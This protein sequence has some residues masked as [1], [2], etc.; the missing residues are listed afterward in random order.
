MTPLLDSEKL[1]EGV[2]PG[3]WEGSA[4]DGSYHD[5]IRVFADDDPEGAIPVTICPQRNSAI[6]EVLRGRTDATT[7]AAANARII[8]AS[9]RLAREHAAM[10][11]A[12]KAIL[13]ELR[14]NPDAKE[15]PRYRNARASKIAAKALNGGS[16]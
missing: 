5:V 1:L 2:T 3:E 6:I 14:H 16:E 4:P 10:K 12:L 11:V 8:A 7:E 13:T 15:P 9:P